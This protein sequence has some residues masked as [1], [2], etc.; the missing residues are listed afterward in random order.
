M[1]VYITGNKL[2]LLRES[3]R[4][5]PKMTYG[6]LSKAI[7]TS[8][9]IIRPI[10]RQ[11]APTKTGKLSR[12]IYAKSSGLEGVVGPNLEVT[13]YAFWVNRGSSAYIIRPKTKKALY[14]SGAEHPWKLVHHPG[15]KANPFVERTFIEMQKPVKLIFNK[16]VDKIISNI[17]R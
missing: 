2:E 10:M 16:A 11:Q 7:K 15:I 4:K 1:E 6:E 8:V 5:A 14:W 12:N 9:H 3:M 13:P 17:L